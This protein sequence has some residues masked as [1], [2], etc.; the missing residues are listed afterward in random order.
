MTHDDIRNKIIPVL[1]PYRV[2]RV[3]LFGSTARGEATDKSDI[4]LLIDIKNDISLIEYIGIKQQ[5]ENVL[6]KN[7]DL[8]EYQAIKPAL[9]QKILK[10]EIVLYE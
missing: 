5:L 1:K 3:G 9:K 10:E 4:D 8:I 6:G 7:V 2:L